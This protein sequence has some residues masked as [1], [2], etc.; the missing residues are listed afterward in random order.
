[1]KEERAVV[2][3]SVGNKQKLFIR[4]IFWNKLC[5]NKKRFTGLILLPHN[6]NL[7]FQTGES[8][9]HSDMGVAAR[10]GW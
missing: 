4:N 10:S 6:R 8:T 9:S 7:F 5:F 1:M 3:V 2:R